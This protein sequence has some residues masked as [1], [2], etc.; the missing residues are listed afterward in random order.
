MP[1]LHGSW[2][3]GARRAG[4]CTP[5]SVQSWPMLCWTTILWRDVRLLR[6][7]HVHAGED[8]DEYGA[9]ASGADHLDGGGVVCEGRDEC[10][11]QNLRM[12]LPQCMPPGVRR[13]SLLLLVNAA[14]VGEVRYRPSLSKLL[15]LGGYPTTP[16]PLPEADLTLASGRLRVPVRRVRIDTTRQ[17]VARPR[18][19]RTVCRPGSLLGC[20]TFSS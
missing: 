5:R 14:E 19:V 12:P 16:R 13:G 17:G 18:P 1:T 6:E 7:Q 2:Q 20:R 11:R 9:R 10:G 3:G 15:D 8:Q 4:R